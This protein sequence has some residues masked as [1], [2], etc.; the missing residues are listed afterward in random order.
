LVSVVSVFVSVVVVS[1]GLVSVV[2]VSEVV[3]SVVVPPP[4]HPVNMPARAAA[5]SMAIAV[6]F[7]DVFD[8]MSV[9]SSKPTEIRSHDSLDRPR[10]SSYIEKL[11]D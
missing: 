3:V 7:V 11:I 5:V 1:T 6:L 8:S 2:D 10:Y 4:E 9:S